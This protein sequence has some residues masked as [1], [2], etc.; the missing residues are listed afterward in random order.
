MLL[1]VDAVTVSRPERDLFRDVSFTVHSG[2]RLGIVGLNGTGKS[3]LVRV[4]I[5]ELAP[6]A[7][8]V[9]RARD[10]RMAVL[11]QR[12]DLAPGTARSALE[13]D[14]NAAV[15]EIEAICD[16][17][18]VAHLLDAEVSTLSGG[19]AKRVALARALAPRPAVLLLDEP[20]TGLD[21]E[22]HDRLTVEVAGVLR[23]TATTALWVTHDRAEAEAVA[24]RVVRLD[25]LGKEDVVG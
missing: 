6:D 10:L 15:W 24:D 2:D 3:T 14:D 16:R 23:R 13:A 4:A 19:E 11:G 20:L 18:G 22:L 5:G 21:R 9:R 25:E 12:P 1:D 17:L 8:Q 7:G